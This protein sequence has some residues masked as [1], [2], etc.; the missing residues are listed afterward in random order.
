MENL[1]QASEELKHRYAPQIFKYN[2]LL[3]SF[4]LQLIIFFRTAVLRKS[5]NSLS[6]LKAYDYLI[7]YVY[8]SKCY[9]CQCSWN[10]APEMGLNEK[11]RE[12]WFQITRDIAS[13]MMSQNTFS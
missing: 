12:T 5:F 9:L 3:C 10:E 13:L 11:T 2:P 1:K 8:F 7:K 6:P 4:T